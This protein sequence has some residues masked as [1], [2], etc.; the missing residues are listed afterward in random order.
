MVVGASRSMPATACWYT[1]AVKV[2][3]AWPSRALTI[4]VNARLERGSLTLLFGA[5]FLQ[6]LTVDGSNASVRE[7]G[8][9]CRRCRAPRRSRQPGSPARPILL[10]SHV[11]DRE[12]QEPDLIMV[13][14]FVRIV[15][16]E[17]VLASGPLA[18]RIDPG[19]GSKRKILV[20]MSRTGWP[21][22]PK[23]GSRTGRREE[24]TTP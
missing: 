3:D 6:A 22:R 14:D 7:R 10:M 2:S 19:E 1:L 16:D 12:L 5:P 4:E 20:G 18:R 13:A 17:E 24:R 8:R 11:D 23:A 15:R 21:L 9:S